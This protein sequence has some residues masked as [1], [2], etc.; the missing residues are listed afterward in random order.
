[1]TLLVR[2][3]E[4]IIRENI[5]FH[6]SQGV[7]YFIATD[8]RSIDG[9]ADILREYEAKGVLH[10]SFEGSDQHIAALFLLTAPFNLSQCA[11]G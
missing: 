1:M 2:N 7:S 6:L 11:L 10:C 9:T 4:D 8:N 3:E 5:E